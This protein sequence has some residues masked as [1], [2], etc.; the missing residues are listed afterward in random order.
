MT[1]E[2]QVYFLNKKKL[3]MKFLKKG[4]AERPCLRFGP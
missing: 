1:L 4:K 2:K 3:K